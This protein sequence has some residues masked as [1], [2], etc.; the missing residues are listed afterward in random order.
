MPERLE[1]KGT[2]ETP[3]IILDKEENIFKIG[4]H[5]MPENPN[6]FYQDII[7]WFTDY[8]RNPKK[9]TILQ[10]EFEYINSS[11]S[12]IIFELLKMIKEVEDSGNFFKVVWMCHSDDALIEEKGE[13]M[14]IL[15]NIPFEIQIK[16]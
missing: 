13:E 15:L 3:W 2:E 16:K 12:K 9:K 10:C 8:I 5:S 6:Y 4:G 14:K 7:D 1:R 11:S